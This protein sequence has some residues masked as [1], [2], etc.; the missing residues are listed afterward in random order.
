MQQ[1]VDTLSSL[2]YFEWL[3]ITGVALGLV[4]YYLHRQGTKYDAQVKILRD[5]LVVVRDVLT[6]RR[7]RKNNNTKDDESDK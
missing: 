3:V 1:I 2:T 5:V 4:E 7:R 6:A